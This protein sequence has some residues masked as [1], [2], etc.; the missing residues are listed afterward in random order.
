MTNNFLKELNKEQLNAVKKTDGPMLIIAGAGTGKTKV[1]TSKIAYLIHQKKAKPNEILALTFTEKAANEMEERLDIL[2]PYG[3][4]DTNIMTFHSF[5][6]SIISDYAFSLGINSDFETLTEEKQTIILN[7]NIFNFKLKYFKPISNPLKYVKIILKFISRCKDELIEPEKIIKYAKDNL[8]KTKDKNQKKIFE[9]YLELGNIYKKYNQILNQNDFIDYGDQI[10]ITIKLLKDHPDIKKEIIKRYKY[11]LVDEFQDTNYSQYVLIKLLLNKQ[12]NITVVGDDDQSIYK[13]RGASISNILNFTKDFPQTQTVVL[14]KNYR[15]SQNILDCAYK[16]IQNNNPERLEIKQKINKKLISNFTDIDPVINIFSDYYTE[17]QYISDE[18]KKLTQQKKIKYSDIAII[19]RSN[20]NYLHIIENFKS[21]KIPYITKTNEDLYES[22]I[23]KT[24]I[25]LIYF[26]NDPENS[27]ALFQILTSSIYNFEPW[28]LSKLNSIANK[29]NLS[30]RYVIENYQD[31]ATLDIK[32]QILNKLNDTILKLK[33]FSLIA[34]YKTTREL[35]YKFIQ[36]NNLLKNVSKNN[37]EQIALVNFFKKIEE[38]EKISIDKSIYNYI[39]YLNKELLLGSINSIFEDYELNAVSIITAHSAKGLE[40]DT[41]FLPALTN[42]YFPT[43]KKT[44]PFEIPKELIKENLPEKDFHLE[45]ERRLFYVAIT[46]A[47]KKLYLSF[48]QTYGGVREK[49]PSIFI[50]EALNLNPKEIKIITGKYNLISKNEQMDL[51]K[52]AKPLNKKII[53]NAHKI[54]D[55]ITCPL[56]YY[57]VHEINVP[58]SKHSSV[59]YGSAIHKA[60]EFYLKTKYLIKKDISLDEIIK[61]YKKNWQKDGFYN[62]K[63]EEDYFKLGIKSLKQF[64]NQKN[65]RKIIDIE[66]KFDFNFS[67]KIKITGRYDIVYRKNNQI[68]I[69]DFKTSTIENQKKANARIRS[70][71]QMMVYALAYLHNHKK[72]PHKLSLEFIGSKF[73]AEIIPNQKII[74]KISKNIIETY[75][76]IAK[77]IYTAK[78]NKNTCSYCAYKSICPKKFKNA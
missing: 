18:I 65:K 44:D 29:S 50:S 21:N 22:E 3:N 2:V 10:N 74:D 14:N 7:E 35:L 32:K 73:T 52:D 4:I 26:L 33:N 46:R 23:V 25:N 8:K 68:Y 36:K 42:D 9:K 51:F 62:K 60:I 67:K 28:D 47:K 72:L 20:A 19:T 71:R 39:K 59:I 12:K 1:I 78:P 13:F 49:K 16:L 54:D 57:Y 56:K 11:I 37:L 77:K 63:Q 69:G 55:Y 58:I 64:I 41:V 61:I 76:G 31:F 27:L 40:F 5:G 15:S 17:A 66:Q 6:Q 53:L 48:A 75:E 30:L 34:R 70:S 45:E 24:C 38:F 43:R